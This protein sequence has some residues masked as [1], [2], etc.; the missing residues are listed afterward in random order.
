M[1]GFGPEPLRSADQ[2]QK[3]LAA[4]GSGPWGPDSSTLGRNFSPECQQGAFCQGSAYIHQ[5]CINVVAGLSIHRDEEGQAA[6]QR[7]DIHAPILIMVPGQEPDAAIL[8][9]DARGH[10]VECLWGRKVG[11]Q[12]LFRGLP[13]SEETVRFQFS[14]THL[15]PP[16]KL[17]PAVPLPESRIPFHNGDVPSYLTA[18]VS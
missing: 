4:G 9:P 14:R 3:R 8:R 10:Y 2:K 6:I 1:S 13:R 16:S 15:S 5:C 11:G 18:L 7:Q 17:G 12:V